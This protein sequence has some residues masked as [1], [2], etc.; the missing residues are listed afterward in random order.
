M[1]KET[2]RV[3]RGIVVEGAVPFLPS[4]FE[5]S[6]CFL[7]QGLVV[8]DAPAWKEVDGDDF[9]MTSNIFI[10]SLRNPLPFFSFFT[11]VIIKK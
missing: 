9:L 2:I 8:V 6:C 10:I 11:G 4:M 1:L 3:G 5:S 7:S